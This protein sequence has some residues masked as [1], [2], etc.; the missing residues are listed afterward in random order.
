MC[1]KRSIGGVTHARCRKKHGLD[2]LISIFVYHGLVRRLLGKLKYGL[3][4]DLKSDLLELMATFGD[5]NLI[6]DK[7]WMVVSVPLYES[8]MRKRGF[9]Q[10]DLIAEMIAEYFGWEYLKEVL[11]RNRK[12][13]KQVALKKE[14]RKLN[15]LGAF[16]LTSN[17]KMGV[18]NKEI[19]L[20]DDVWTTGATLKECSKVLKRSG[21]N[22][23][24]GLTFAS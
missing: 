13:I 20:V 22:K 12:T 6:G 8:R 4:R 16:G 11:Y 7:N 2:G 15:V 23:V 10:A 14:K 3:V 1:T 17:L 9:N 21:A 18:V 5:F 24:W 19:L